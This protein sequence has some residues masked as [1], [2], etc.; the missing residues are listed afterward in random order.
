[1]RKCFTCLVTGLLVAAFGCGKEDP[2]DRPGFVDTS[3]P[4]KVMETMKAPP[5]SKDPTALGVKN[6]RPPGAK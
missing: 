1:M 6:T 4:S 5:K 2:R 3:D